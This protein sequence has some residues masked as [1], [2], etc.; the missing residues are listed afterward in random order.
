MPPLL[1]FVTSNA[2]RRS[3]SSHP[4]RRPYRPP[5]AMATWFLTSSG[6]VKPRLAATSEAMRYEPPTEHERHCSACSLSSSRRMLFDRRHPKDATC[7]P[8]RSAA[9]SIAL[10]MI[11]GTAISSPPIAMTLVLTLLDELALRGVHDTDCA[12]KFGGCLSSAS[13]LPPRTHARSG[14]ARRK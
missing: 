5:D 11:P 3:V 9:R 2:V 13:P 7:N 12:Q 8:P 14:P 1:P 6:E 4:A 10:N